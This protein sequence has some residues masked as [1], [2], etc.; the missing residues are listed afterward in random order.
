MTLSE[1]P[2]LVHVRDGR[3][4]KRLPD[5]RRR[6]GGFTLIDVTVTMLVALILAGI[7]VPSFS[8]FMDR[9]TV[10]STASAI[11]AAISNARYRSIM[12]SQVYTVAVTAP[13]NTYVVTNIGTG[14][15]DA[16]V[17]LPDPI[18]LLNGG[19]SGTYT[20]TLCPNGTVYGTGGA[21][22][23]NSNP[24]ALAFTYQGREVDINVSSAGNVTSTTIH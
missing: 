22:P 8:K 2:A 17:P 16:A 21:C 9:M 23:G 19:S 1:T 3:S 7:A 18:V 15:A 5:A 24:P 13:A 4:S 12:N 6:S 20:F 14:T 11:S 10:N